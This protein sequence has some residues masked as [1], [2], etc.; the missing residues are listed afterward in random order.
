VRAAAQAAAEAGCE[1]LH[2]DYEASLDPF[3]LA[4]GFRPTAAGLLGLSPRRQ[5]TSGIVE[6]TIRCAVIEDLPAVVAILLEIDDLHREGLPWL[7]RQV[8]QA[9]LGGFLEDYITKHDRTMLLATTPE[10]PLAPLAGVLYLFIRPPARAPIVRPAVVAEI[11]ALVVSASARR[12][13]VGSRLVRAALQWAAAQG[14]TRTELGVY[15]FNEAA[16]DF[17]ASVGFETLSRRL[18][19]HPKPDKGP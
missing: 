5:R 17:W 2:V 3:Y 15:E 11:D 18:V 10:G 7:F 6:V 13:G 12:L 4:C 16:R 9:A 8:D 1:N 14:A 19:A